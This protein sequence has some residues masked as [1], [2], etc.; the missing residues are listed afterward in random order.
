MQLGPQKLTSFWDTQVPLQLRW[1]LGHRPSQAWV[2]GVQAPA[3][4]W[5]PEGHSAPHLVPSQVALP[6]V[7]T[8]Q[9][10]Q[11]PPQLVGLLS[12]RQ[13]SL[14]RWKPGLHLSSHLSPS[15]VLTP[16]GEEGQGEQEE[17]QAERLVGETQMPLHRF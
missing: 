7:G 3:Q 5:V 15:Q 16:S 11:E 9:G 2:R 8:G 1:P 4:S 10:A 17:P 6:P 13:A 12:S 14:Q